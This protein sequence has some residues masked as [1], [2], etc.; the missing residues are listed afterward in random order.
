MLLFKIY[1]K[2]QKVNMHVLMYFLHLVLPFTLAHYITMVKGLLVQVS[3]FD[4]DVKFEISHGSKHLYMYTPV[5]HQM[6]R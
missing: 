2:A 6:M 5:S 3:Q 4:R 1:I